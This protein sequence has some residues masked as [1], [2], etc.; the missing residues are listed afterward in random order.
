[1]TGPAAK[2]TTAEICSAANCS[3]STLARWVRR[4][5]VAPCSRVGRGAGGM[6]GYYPPETL[7]RVKR[8]VELRELGYT[9]DEVKIQLDKAG[10]GAPRPKK[11]TT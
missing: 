5:L 11:G 2:V 4:G 1:M 10:R 6:T 7:E 9:L 3:P 8:I